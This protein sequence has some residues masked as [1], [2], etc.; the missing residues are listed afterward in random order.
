MLGRIPAYGIPLDNTVAV[1]EKVAAG[2][3]APGL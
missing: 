1:L 2:D 3:K